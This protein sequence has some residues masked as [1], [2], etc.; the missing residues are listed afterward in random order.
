ML[1]TIFVSPNFITANYVLPKENSIPIL[2]LRLV[3][4]KLAALICD[5]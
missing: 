3:Y 2:N 5:S 1:L 4:G